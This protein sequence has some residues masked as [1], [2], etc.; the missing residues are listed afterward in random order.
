MFTYLLTEFAGTIWPVRKRFNSDHEQRARPK[1]WL[2]G[3]GDHHYCMHG[4]LPESSFL[5]MFMS[6]PRM[7]NLTRCNV[8]MEA[9]E[10]DGCIHLHELPSFDRA[11][12]T[13]DHHCKSETKQL[14]IALCKTILAV[15]EQ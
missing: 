14:E 15:I 13:L 2:S 6:T 8:M 12:S 4:W 1:S 5:Y 7:T 10:V 3:G 11:L 9:H